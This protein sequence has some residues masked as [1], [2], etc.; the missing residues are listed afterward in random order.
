[1]IPDGPI[2]Q[3]LAAVRAVLHWRDDVDDIVDELADH[4]QTGAERLAPGVDALTAEESAVARFGR[5]DVVTASFLDNGRG[6]RAAPS[7]L[8]RAGGLALLVAGPLWVV[9]GAIWAVSFYRPASGVARFGGAAVTPTALSVIMTLTLIGCV[10]WA[11]R[12]TSPLTWWARSGLA[13]ATAAL[14]V[15]VMAPDAVVLW[16]GLLGAGTFALGR[17]HA[18]CFTTATPPAGTLGVLRHWYLGT[19]PLQLILVL[20][21]PEVSDAAPLGW[22]AGFAALG[23]ALTLLGQALVGERA[24]RPVSGA[25]V[26]PV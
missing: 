14:G 26:Q 21:A 20:L 23:C 9:V 12:I 7:H 15:L 5:S 16:A 4:L 22:L 11:H 8:S 18:R 13:A 17:E 3:H 19:I 10:G 25:T 24:A 1:M 2:V 6:Q